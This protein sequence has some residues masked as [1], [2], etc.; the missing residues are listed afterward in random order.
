VE[1][2]LQLVLTNAAAAAVLAGV[3]FAVSRVVRRPALAHALWLIA[4][5]KLVTPPLLPLP[6]LPRWELVPTLSAPGSPTFV[7]MT[8]DAPPL[9]R[10]ATAPAPRL[11][12]AHPA[13]TAAA[14]A[15]RAPVPNA[16]R[17]RLLAAVM[18]S[19][20]TVAV[21]GLAALRFMRFRRTLAWAEPAPAAIEACTARLSA[22][23]GLRRAPRVLVVPARIPPMLWPE[24]SGPRLLL[25]R[26][27]LPELSPAECDAL[28][29]HE[30]AHVQRRDHWVRL[31][32]LVATAV[33][34][35]YPLTWW[36]R[37][38]L[39]RAE[40]R[41]CDE[42]V[43]RVLPR[44]AQAYANG[45]LKSLSFVSSAP[46][47]VPALASGV[48][49]LYELELRLKEI[50]MSRPA[51]CLAPPVRLA[52]LAAAAV[53]LAVFPI[54]AREDESST[55]VVAAAAEAP[56]PAKPA[57]A[58]APARVPAPARAGAPAGAGAPS[59]VAAPAS[60]AQAV[61]PA[62]TPAPAQPPAR[63]LRSADDSHRALDEQRR[64][65]E[66]KRRS[67]QQQEL[68]LSRLELELNAK[69]EQAELRAAAEQMRA[70]GKARQ[71]ELYEKQL[72]MTG[73]RME[74]ER[75]RLK[76]DSERLAIE[77]KLEGAERAQRD[78]LAALEGSGSEDARKAAELEIER[79][80][81]Q[82]SRTEEELGKAQRAL[83]LEAESLEKELQKLAAEEQIHAVSEATDE[84]ARSLAEQ[85]ES[86]KAALQETGA[87]PDVERE[88]KRLEAAL[89]ALKLSSPSPTADKTPK[90]SP[91]P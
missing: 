41:C 62:T 83:E 89:A 76:L 48:S 25:P 13:T 39:R 11:V 42:W 67:L 73:R 68:E 5:V 56:Q 87:R 20:G 43:L 38:A 37:R 82:R 77:M 6:L 55:A 70:E 81:A 9:P 23:L 3:A 61:S 36:M 52:L 71:A 4:L 14:H 21:L 65:L 69:A 2:A 22:E 47:K 34:W 50:L 16:S 86:L 7:R 12:P 75:R 51:P 66:A 58:S 27:L 35:W 15:Q 32:E 28:L 78:K 63:V 90:P 18:L 84:M 44:S 49:P 19:F 30:L 33:F 88:I 45:L 29:A 85:V 59:G 53:G 74:L 26:D 72:A 79:A 57:R 40:E 64:E 31:V 46:A 1:A 91:Q 24:P 17:L 60:L 54:H 8:P 10:L 80:E